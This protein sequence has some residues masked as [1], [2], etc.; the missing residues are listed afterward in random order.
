M[1]QLPALPGNAGLA[2]TRFGRALAHGPF[3]LYCTLS[4]LDMASLFRILP[5][6]LMGLWLAPHA[7]AQ[8]PV[9]RCETDGRVSYSSEPCVGAREIDVTPTQ[10]LDKMTG[11][12]RKSADVL[13][14][15]L[16]NAVSKALQ[17]LTGMTPE[18][19][20]VHKRRIGLSA[21]DKADCARLDAT[22]PE[23]KQRASM[24]TPAEHTEADMSLY[25]ARKQFNDLNC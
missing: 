13:R 7:H 23:L 5:P 16:D 24:A 17:P 19:F 21:R 25:K 4:H 6:L 12:S 22:L 1:L 11:K 10:G 2:V 8:K 14:Q 3:Q 15:E 20:A 9:Y 18:Q